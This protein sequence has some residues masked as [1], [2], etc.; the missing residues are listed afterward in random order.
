LVRRHRGR[1]G[2]ECVLGGGPDAKKFWICA[3]ARRLVFVVRWGRDSG[4]AGGCGFFGAGEFCHPM[5][6]EK[7]PGSVRF[8]PAQQITL[9]LLR[10]TH[11]AGPLPLA[12]DSAR[13]WDYGCIRI[14]NSLTIGLGWKKLGRVD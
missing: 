6:I 4:T 7:A 3:V 8:G 1:S 14:P 13:F 11:G 12:S 2:R 9:R 5:L 10:P